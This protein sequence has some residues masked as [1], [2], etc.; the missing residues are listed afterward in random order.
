[1]DACLTIAYPSYSSIYLF[2]FGAR[3]SIKKVLVI[4]ICDKLLHK[5]ALRLAASGS[6]VE[7]GGQDL[8][9]FIP[10]LPARYEN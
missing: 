5:G 9:F 3:L 2:V 10:L 8:L 1:M 7:L 4:N 6:G